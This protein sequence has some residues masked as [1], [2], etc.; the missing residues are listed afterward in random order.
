MSSRATAHRGTGWHPNRMDRLWKKKPSINDAD[1]RCLLGQTVCPTVS[2]FLPMSG[3]AFNIACNATTRFLSQFLYPDF[4]RAVLSILWQADWVTISNS[5]SGRLRLIINW[6]RYQ[7]FWTFC[8]FTLMVQKFQCSSGSILN[9][10]D[11]AELSPVTDRIRYWSPSHPTECPNGVSA[12][13]SCV[14][15]VSAVIH[16]CASGPVTDTL[17]DVWQPSRFY[18]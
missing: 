15:H 16:V 6:G 17:H 12:P 3:F 14:F 9:Q 1:S 8:T 11:R 2:A 13:W 7:A 4:V 5:I 18:R 10:T